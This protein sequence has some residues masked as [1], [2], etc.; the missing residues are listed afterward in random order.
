MSVPKHS[1]SR[2]RLHTAGEQSIFVPYSERYAHL[3]A[4]SWTTQSAAKEQ[5]NFRPLSYRLGPSSRG[6]SMCLPGSTGRSHVKDIV[7]VSSARETE[8]QANGRLFY[9]LAG[10]LCFI[11]V[12]SPVR[13]ARIIAWCVW[14]TR[15]TFSF[16]AYIHTHMYMHICTYNYVRLY[17]AV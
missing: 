2:S 15:G 1:K 13:N 12:N 10:C 6:R 4:V 9:G 17:I 14:H 5:P 3:L 7:F 8:V 16:E 11:L